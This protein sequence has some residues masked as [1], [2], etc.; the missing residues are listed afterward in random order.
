MAAKSQSNQEA[1]SPSRDRAF[2]CHLGSTIVRLHHHQADDARKTVGNREVKKRRDLTDE[3]T[4]CPLCDGNFAVVPFDDNGGERMGTLL[5]LGIA[6]KSIWRRPSPFY[7]ART[8]SALESCSFLARLPSSPQFEFSSPSLPNLDSL[9]LKVSISFTGRGSTQPQK[10]QFGCRG[11]LCGFG[12]VCERDPTD[13]SKAECVCKRVECPS[14]V[15]PVCGSDSSTYSNECELEKAQCSAQRRIKST[16]G[17]LFGALE[18]ALSPHHRHSPLSERRKASV[19]HTCCSGSSDILQ[20]A[21]PTSRTPGWLGGE[22]FSKSPAGISPS[23]QQNW[24]Q[25]A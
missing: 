10:M 5:R 22:G 6:V 18:R 24:I 1:F 8:S 13:T 3:Y 11:M 4:D 17:A 20:A 12:A 25:P 21:S 9:C 23:L 19:L 2:S 14:L 7:P 16:L 15:A